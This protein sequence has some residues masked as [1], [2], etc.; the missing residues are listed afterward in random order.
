MSKYNYSTYCNNQAAAN[1]TTD[2]RPAELR[3]DDA[4]QIAYLEQWHIE[5]PRRDYT[6]YLALIVIVIVWIS[7]YA[8]HRHNLKA[9]YVTQLKTYCSAACHV[10]EKPIIKNAA[11]Y[12]RIHSGRTI[13]DDKAAIDELK[14][15][16]WIMSQ[17]LK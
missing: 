8:I 9:A 14:R 17:F 15:Q 6:G 11:Q 4:D 10:Y 12:G 5:H 2:N 3:Y 13:A 1:R 7:L 16:E